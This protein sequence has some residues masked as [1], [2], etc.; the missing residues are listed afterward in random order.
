MKY[1]RDLADVRI[2]N[3]DNIAWNAMLDDFSGN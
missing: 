1:F 2:D 3:Y